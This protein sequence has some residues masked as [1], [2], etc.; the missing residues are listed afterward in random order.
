V[1]AAREVGF[2]KREAVRQR[3]CELRNRVRAASA[4]W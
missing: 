1:H 4:M 3:E 2:H